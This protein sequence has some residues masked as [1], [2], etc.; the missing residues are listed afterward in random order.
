MVHL[1]HTIGIFGISNPSWRDDFLSL[2][3][4]NLLITAFLLFWGNGVF[5]NRLIKTAVIV[6]GIGFVIE[7]IGVKTG[8]L[9]G[10]YSYGDPLGVKLFEVPLMIGVNWL[11]L[12]FSSIG[13]ASKMFKSKILQV[14]AS[15][16]L[17]V[18][19][20]FLIEPVAIKLNFW[21]WNGGYIPPQNYLMWFGVIYFNFDIKVILK[22]KFLLAAS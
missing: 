18:A 21:S 6:F 3:P 22:H 14:I 5:S 20:D 12:S 13:I 11:V 2:T 15:S 17:L 10:T 9:F 16:L 8:A 19:L 4:I 7:V 1:F